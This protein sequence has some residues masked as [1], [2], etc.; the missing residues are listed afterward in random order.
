MFVDACHDLW[1]KLHRFFLIKN[2]LKQKPAS[3]AISIDGLVLKC[4]A[5]TDYC[6]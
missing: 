4:L 5:K 3:Q 6:I 2:E 1:E